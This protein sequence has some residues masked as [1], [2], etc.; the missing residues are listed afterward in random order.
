MKI[1][2]VPKGKSFRA[3]LLPM[4]LRACSDAR[5]WVGRKSL[6]VAWATCDRPDWMMW[7]VRAVGGIESNLSVRIVCGCA[8]EAL[9]YA[10]S[11]TAVSTAAIDLAERR[12]GG[13]LTVT[14]E[15]LRTAA[16]R[17]ARPLTLA[18]VLLLRPP[19]IAAPR[20]RTAV[21]LLALAPELHLPAALPL[22]HTLFDETP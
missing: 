19:A 15:E 5:K 12:A 17:R 14:V 4:N 11:A 7:L 2:T 9:P 1:I 8:R 13:D 20:C 6:R 16:R 22:R 21:R 10:G 3:L 18:R